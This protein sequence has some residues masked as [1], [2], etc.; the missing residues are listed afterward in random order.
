MSAGKHGGRYN[1]FRE[2]ENKH[3]IQKITDS[4]S[5]RNKKIKSW[6]ISVLECSQNL[7]N[8]IGGFYFVL[9]LYKVCWRCSIT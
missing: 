8:D 6:D 9:N 3:L 5:K 1:S 4:W 2:K 7:S